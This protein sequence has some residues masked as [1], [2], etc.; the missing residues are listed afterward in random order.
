MYYALVDEIASSHGAAGAR[1]VG[2][3]TEPLTTFVH[4]PKTA[5]TPVSYVM[6]RQFPRGEIIDLDASTVEEANQRWDA[7]AP[8]ERNR[9][10]CIRGHLPF[11]PEL[12]APR[13]RRFF[14]VLRDPVQRVISEYYYNL[15]GPKRLLYVPLN[16]TRMTLDQFV[17][18]DLSAQVHNGQTRILAGART[19][20]NP[21]ELLDLAIANLREQMALVGISER[22]DGTLLLCRA[23]LGWRYVIYR[24]VNVTPSRPPLRA[25][26]PATLSAIEQANPLDRELYRVGCSRF[27]ALLR[28]HDITDS[29]ITALHRASRI[30]GAARRIVGIPREVWSKLRGAA[31]RH[32]AA[33]R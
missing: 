17:R 11:A 31:D 25:I 6:W 21:Q 2:S 8:E 22:L 30:Y 15:A 16:R 9:V 18:S 1:T 26:S 7:M 19:D 5:G 33:D 23:V 24:T 4:I 29:Q 32:D 20:L 12:F 3:R 27:E 10:R 28:E 13:A 14:T